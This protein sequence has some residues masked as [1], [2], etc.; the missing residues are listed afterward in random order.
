MPLMILLALLL[1][2]AVCLQGTA[3][4]QLAGRIGLPLTLTI[5]SGM[6]F[7]GALGWLAIAHFSGSTPAERGETSWKLYTG[8]VFGLVII[9]CAAVA[10]PRLGAG[11][12]TTLAVGA[13]VVT[14]LVLDQVGA[15]GRQVPLTPTRLAGVACVALGV[16][17]VMRPAAPAAQ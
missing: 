15:T 2:I 16:W 10:Y 9:S 11:V 1:G 5:N 14:A 4:G 8:G 13:Q 17:L 12:T 7:F 6:V 3:N